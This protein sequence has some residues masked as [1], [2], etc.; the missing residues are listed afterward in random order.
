MPSSSEPPP[1]TDEFVS[2]LTFTIW[3]R[4]AK[5]RESPTFPEKI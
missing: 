1:V 2:S 4:E 5:R 3:I